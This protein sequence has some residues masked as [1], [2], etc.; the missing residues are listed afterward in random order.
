MPQKEDPNIRRSYLSKELVTS[1]A[2]G[3]ETVADVLP[4]MVCSFDFSTINRLPWVLWIND[5]IVITLLQVKKYGNKVACYNRKIVKIVEEKKTIPK[6]GGA[7]GETEEKLWK[8]S[9]PV[10][11]C[12]P[13]RKV[14][15]A[16]ALLFL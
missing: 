2:D 11:S 4:W 14:A 13:N 10:R 6:K 3:V 8:L 1:P 9:V 15:N 16:M 7:E 12:H 5:A